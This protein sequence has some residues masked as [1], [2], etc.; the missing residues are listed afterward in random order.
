AD[1]L[2]EDPSTIELLPESIC[3]I[4][5][6]YEVDHPFEKQCALLATLGRDFYVAPG[7]ST[8]TSYTGRLPTMVANV[9]SAAQ[10]GKDFG[11]SGLLMTHWGD[12][13]HPQ[14]WPVSLPGLVW[15]GLQSWNSQIEEARL[16]HGLRHVLGDCNGI[17][18][19]TLLAAGSVDEGLGVH[20]LNKS[21]LAEANLLTETELKELKTQPELF[22]LHQVKRD[23]ERW[24][25]ALS[26]AELS[27]A[28][29]AQ[30]TEEL[31]LAVRLNLYAISRC[32]GKSDAGSEELRDLYCRC[33]YYRSRPD[34][35]EESLVKVRGMNGLKK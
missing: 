16:E 8:W 23:C 18:V 5:W 21:F 35:L 11:A 6:G 25:R 4:I 15:A 2:L 28:D 9:R 19:Q 7:D 29:S 17:Y 12:N 27:V 10:V 30:L 20:R 3:P 32:L 31:K 24:I 26:D 34:G 1:V 22:S 14:P 13:G 33:W